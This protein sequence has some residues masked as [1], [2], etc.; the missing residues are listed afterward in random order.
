MV[1]KKFTQSELDRIRDAVTEAEKSTAGEIVTYF[2]NT[3]DDYEEVTLRSALMFVVAPLVMFSLLSY[4]WLLPFNVTPLVMGIACIILGFIGYVLPIIWP[5]YRRLILSQ[6]RLQVAVERRAMAAFLSEEV[7]S[8]ENRTGILIFISYFEHMVEVIGDSGINSR[9][10]Q[11][12]WEEVVQLITAGIKN[13]DAA[14]GII[15]GVARCGE[16]LKAAGVHKPPDNPNE[17]S[18]DMRIS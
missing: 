5:A 14:G 1:M 15:N 2:V 8:T 18:D 17:L 11:S 9:V 7:F 3:S 13:K 10:E 4:G 12:E 6:S 16:L